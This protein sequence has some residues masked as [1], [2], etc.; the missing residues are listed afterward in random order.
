MSN[1]DIEKITENK[2]FTPDMNVPEIITI[3]ATEQG[4]ID[5]IIQETLKARWLR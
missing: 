4:I 2:N 1:F 5:K 3:Y